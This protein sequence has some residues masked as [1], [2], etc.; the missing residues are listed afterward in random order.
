M[1]LDKR[2]K[3]LIEMSRLK[4]ITQIKAFEQNETW[5]LMILIWVLIKIRIVLLQNNQSNV[6]SLI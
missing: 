1:W 5:F 3:I 4:L 6:M 2:D